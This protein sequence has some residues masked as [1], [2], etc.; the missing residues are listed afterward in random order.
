M[1]SGPSTA[2][3]GHPSLST[4]TLRTRLLKSRPGVSAEPA[5]AWPKWGIGGVL[6]VSSYEMRF[7]YGDSTPFPLGYNFLATL[8]AFMAA[9]TRMVLLDLEGA[10]IV[11]QRDELA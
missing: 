5:P 2:S 4:S 3:P 11:K 10:Q 8:E 9:S 6:S 7:L 1:R